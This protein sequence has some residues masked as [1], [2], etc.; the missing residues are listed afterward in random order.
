MDQVLGADTKIVYRHYAT[1]YF[2]LVV[3]GSESEL[4]ILDLIQATTSVCLLKLKHVGWDGLLMKGKPDAHAITAQVFV[5]T[6]DKQFENVCELDLIFHH[7]KAPIQPSPH[8]RPTLYTLRMPLRVL[9]AGLCG[10]VVM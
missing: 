5:E 2:I 6:L 3:D 1:L 7:D 4:G 8:P 9:Y 10:C